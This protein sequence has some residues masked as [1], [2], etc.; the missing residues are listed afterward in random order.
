MKV[1]NVGVSIFGQ[2]L[3]WMVMTYIAQIKGQLLQLMTENMNLFDKMHEGL[4]VVSEDD[5]TL[6]FASKS[7]VSLLTEKP[8]KEKNW[9]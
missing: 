6:Q 2:T 4:V 3:F 1:L 8:V 5:Q 9:V 7:A